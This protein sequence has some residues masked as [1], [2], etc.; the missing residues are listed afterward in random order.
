MLYQH[1]HNTAHTRSTHRLESKTTGRTQRAAVKWPCQCRYQYGGN[2]GFEGCWALI[3]KALPC[4]S[5]G[6]WPVIAAVCGLTSNSRGD[7]AAVKRA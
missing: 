5:T 3:P 7:V 2:A 4:R 6:S 1:A